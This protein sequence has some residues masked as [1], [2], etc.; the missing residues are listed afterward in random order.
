GR[1]RMEGLW[2]GEIL[3]E[4]CRADD[5]PGIVSNQ[6]TVGLTGKENLTETSHDEWI[7][8]PEQDRQYEDHQHSGAGVLQQTL[9]GDRDTCTHENDASLGQSEHRHDHV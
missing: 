4:Q 2:A 1:S 7:D 5:I 3:A 6:A 8:D 9:A